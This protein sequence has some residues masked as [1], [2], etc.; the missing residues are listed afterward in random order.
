MI[1]GKLGE[2]VI[3]TFTVIDRRNTLVSD[4]PVTEFSAHLFDP[5]DNEVY[6][7]SDVV[8][9]ELGYGHYKVSYTP[10]QIG[11]WL[12]VA[13]HP[14]YFPWGKSENIQIFANDFDSV[15]SMLQRVLG[16][17]QENFS[18]D[19]TIYDSANNLVSSRVR[20]YSN[21]SSIG[22]DFDILATYSMTAI[23]N[24]SKMTFYKMEKI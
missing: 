4:I 18:V 21:S 6:S 20:T 13:Y 12:L 1:L 16:L 22:T 5:S 14:V 7:S 17:V 9:K 2:A 10:N 3:E 11:T 19:Q 23:Y 8:F 24:E 15:A